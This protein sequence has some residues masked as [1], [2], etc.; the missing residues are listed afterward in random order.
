MPAAI[1]TD[2][3][4]VLV[5]LVIAAITTEPWSRYLSGS[6]LNRSFTV[7]V[8]FKGALADEVAGPSPSSLAMAKAVSAS[9]RGDQASAVRVPSGLAVGPS[10]L[11]SCCAKLSAA[12][13]SSTRSCGRFG[14]ATLG[15]TARRS[16]SRVSEYSASGEP[17]VW[18][19][20]CSL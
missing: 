13:L 10:R 5:Q 16:S 3:L 6:T 4:D 11:G 7:V 15:S 1:I 20:P 9:A 17:E 19:R 14:P 8:T 12:S 2:G 18:N